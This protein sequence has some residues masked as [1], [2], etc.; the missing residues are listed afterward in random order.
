MHVRWV[1]ILQRFLFKL[2][3]KAG[4]RNKVPNAL[5]WWANLMIVLSTK[6]VRF[7]CIKELYKELYSGDDDL[8]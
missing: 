3:H 5:S 1:I 2:I 8:K 4:L 7:D 6:I